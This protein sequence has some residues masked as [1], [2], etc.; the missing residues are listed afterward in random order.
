M[1]GRDVRAILFCVSTTV[2]LVVVSYAAFHS[3]LA[4]LALTAA[5]DVWLLTRPRMVRLF[6]RMRGDPD[7]SG[8]FKND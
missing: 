6:R 8:Y 5:Y 2:A 3:F 7:W 1:R 4:T